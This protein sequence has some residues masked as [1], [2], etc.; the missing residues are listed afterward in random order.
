M[1]C[2]AA[3]NLPL[4]ACGALAWRRGILG[5]SHAGLS[6][7]SWE[8]MVAFNEWCQAGLEESVFGHNMAF[9]HSAR[10]CMQPR[11]SVL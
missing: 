9:L 6:S 4:Q 5:L 7:L 10:D 3:W 1:I 11:V 2:Y 8:V